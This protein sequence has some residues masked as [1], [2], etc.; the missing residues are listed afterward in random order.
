MNVR[1]PGLI[2]LLAATVFILSIPAGASEGSGGGAGGRLDFIGKVV[3]FIVLFGGLAFLLRKPLTKMLADRTESVRLGLVEA[4]RSNREAQTRLREVEARAGRLEDEI[5]GMK[6]QARAAGEAEKDRILRAARQEAERL[7]TFSEQ[8]VEALVR[9]GLRQLREYASDKALAL[10]LER[11]QGGL[12]AELHGRLIDTA[13][14]R[15]AEVYE[16]RDP[17]PSLR[18][19]TH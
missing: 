19:R 17:D 5:D 15:L 9:S 6:T 16:K 14:E 7:K 4:E 11:I 13:I 2:L 3:N 8:E 10:A 1:R 12:T 18:P